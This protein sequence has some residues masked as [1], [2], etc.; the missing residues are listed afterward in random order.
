MSTQ[1]TATRDRQGRSHARAEG[2]ERQGG[3]GTRPRE[4]ATAEGRVLPAL[5][6]RTRQALYRWQ[7]GGKEGPR[8]RLREDHEWRHRSRKTEMLSTQIVGQMEQQESIKSLKPNEGSLPC[9]TEVAAPNTTVR[10]LKNT[11]LA[12]V[13]GKTGQG[14]ER[15]METP[16]LQ[17]SRNS[18]EGKRAKPEFKMKLG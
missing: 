14:R 18:D 13:C 4:A 1:L 3:E 10:N 5:A 16:L 17:A 15:N 8:S 9:L 11:N 6:W 12:V 7:Q 2:A